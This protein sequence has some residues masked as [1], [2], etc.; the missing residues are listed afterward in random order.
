VSSV[1]S[2][3]GD[4]AKY[5][6]NGFAEG[7]QGL[8]Q[9]FMTGLGYPPQVDG[10]QPAQPPAQTTQP[11]QQPAPQQEDRPPLGDSFGQK[12]AALESM[13][14]QYGGGGRPQRGQ[15]PSYERYSPQGQHQQSQ[16]PAQ[17]QQGQQQQ[18]QQPTRQN[19]FNVD[20]YV[21]AIRAERGLGPQQDERVGGGDF[22]LEQLMRVAMQQPHGGQSLV[23]YANT[24]RQANVAQSLFQLVS[25]Q[26][27]NQA[28][29]GQKEAQYQQTFG[30]DQRQYDQDFSR[31]REQQAQNQGNI[32]RRFDQNVFQSNRQFDRGE[33]DADRNH[34][35]RMDRANESDYQFDTNQYNARE[36]AAYA[37]QAAEV[38]GRYEANDRHIK[39]LN[40]FRNTLSKEQRESGETQKFLA[41][42]AQDPQAMEIANSLLQMQTGYTAYRGNKNIADNTGWGQQELSVE[43]IPRYQQREDKR[44]NVSTVF[45]SGKNVVDIKG[46][47]NRE[48]SLRTYG[49]RYRG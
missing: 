40:A 36:S 7:V 1:A 15:E 31:L 33:F 38:K 47:R 16:Y 34:Q 44:G 10:S 46:H 35:Y 42:I 39:T 30:E 45:G 2:P 5:H 27:N 21:A 8:G 17:Q 49:E 9:G 22:N 41:K 13:L 24:K 4:W 12:M 25:G 28:N 29:R 26:R 11:V 14:Q 19:T 37:Q 32:D 6:V 43:G 23:D 18:Q 3:V 20:D 48:D